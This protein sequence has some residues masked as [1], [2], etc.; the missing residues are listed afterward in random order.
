M[1]TLTF[2]CPRYHGRS[3]CRITGHKI[4]RF[5]MKAA[6]ISIYYLIYNL[7]ERILEAT[8][9]IVPVPCNS[10]Y[11]TT[12]I[13]TTAWP[14]TI[15]ASTLA[16]SYGGSVEDFRLEHVYNHYDNS[17]YSRFFRTLLWSTVIFFTLLDRASFPHYNN[18]KII[19]FGHD[20]GAIDVWALTACCNLLSIVMLF[21]WILKITGKK[22]K[23][24]SYATK[25]CPKLL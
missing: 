19:K 11:Y 14:S 8:L 17:R 25:S 10:R 3:N 15:W 20:N 9:A 12:Y 2:C 24:D 1:V 5:V 4:Q 18:T 22:R 23:K 21:I 13:S 7:Q 16:E 6:V